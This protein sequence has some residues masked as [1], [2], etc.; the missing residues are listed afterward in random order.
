MKEI[1]ISNIKENLSSGDFILGSFYNSNVL[2][3]YLYEDCRVKT[4]SMQVQVVNFITSKNY[5]LPCRVV[6]NPLDFSV[7][8]FI[9]VKKNSISSLRLY[10]IESKRDFKTFENLLDKTQLD[11][12]NVMF[13]FPE[14]FLTSSELTFRNFAKK[15]FTKV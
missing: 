14:K 15:F 11:L 10:Q 8:S 6:K 13:D 3:L 4:K 5:L 7:R 1:L 12:I 9:T 2:D